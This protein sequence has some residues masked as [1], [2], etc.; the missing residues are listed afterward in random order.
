MSE[1][2]EKFHNGHRSRLRDKVDNGQ[3]TDAEELET[4]L[5]YVIARRDVRILS[6]TLMQRFG[7]AYNVVLADPEELRR[8]EGVGPSTITF[9]R[10][11]RQIIT[12]GYK[13]H[14]TQNRIYHDAKLIQEYCRIQTMG[15]PV[16]ELHALYLDNEY[17]LI[18]DKLI[19]K[20]SVDH[21]VFYPREIIADATG[22]RASHVV[23]YHNHPVGDTSFST[24]DIAF[25]ISLGKLLRV[26][27]IKLYDHYVVNQYGTVHSMR[28]YHILDEI[29]NAVSE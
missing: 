14:L 15:K 28:N 26:L 16:E 5:T 3:A 18:M 7:S 11:L 17:H 2:D 19:S 13:N 27:G 23:L 25:T 21:A 1:T 29:D 12:K 10:L 22:L 20:G 4:L 8:V 6:R 9:F 24:D